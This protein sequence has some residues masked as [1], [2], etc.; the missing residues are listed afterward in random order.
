[1]LTDGTSVV[2]K[3]GDAAAELARIN[4]ELAALM[5]APAV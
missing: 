1:M 5:H 3:P 2:L 4:A